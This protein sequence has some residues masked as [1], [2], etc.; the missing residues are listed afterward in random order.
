MSDSDT[1]KNEKQVEPE[2]EK[3]LKGVPESML[4]DA[5]ED[6]ADA[7]EGDISDALSALKNDLEA[8]KQ[9]VLYA[10]AE[11]QNVRRRLEKDVADAR[12]YAATGFARDILSVSDNLAR[13]V[14][15]IPEEL[16]EDDKFKGLVAGIEA[17]RRELDKVFGQHGVTRIAAMGLP[18]DPNLHQAMLE[19]PSDDAEPGTVVQEM[20][21]GYTIRD[22]L[23]RPALVGVA[24][25]P[26]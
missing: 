3:E 4:D 5:D 6:T 22:R 12:A 2:V 11:T 18:L 24:K 7:G 17:T 20:Q 15:S 9:E 13:A 21:A 19:I 23:L 8:S 25:K 10:R 16:R 14:D 26:G 1:A